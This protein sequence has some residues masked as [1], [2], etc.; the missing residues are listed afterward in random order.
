MHVAFSFSFIVFFLLFCIVGCILL[1]I[2]ITISSLAVV[3]VTI[4]TNSNRQED[5]SVVGIQ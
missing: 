1:R 2:K 5:V 3:E 4:E